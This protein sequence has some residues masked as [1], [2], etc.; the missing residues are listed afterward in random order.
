MHIVFFSDDFVFTFYAHMYLNKK[1]NVKHF[2]ETN[3][4]PTNIL[5]IYIS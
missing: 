2:F 4:K 1:A 5:K 3:T